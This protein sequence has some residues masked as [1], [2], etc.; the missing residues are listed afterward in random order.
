MAKNDLPEPKS[1]SGF[2][3]IGAGGKKFRPVEGEKAGVFGAP[4]TDFS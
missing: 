1:D 2:A 4:K 3:G